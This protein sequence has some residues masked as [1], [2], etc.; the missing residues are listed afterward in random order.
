MSDHFQKKLACLGI[1]RSP[2]CVRPPEGNGGAE[3]FIRTPKENLLWVPTVDTVEQL[4]HAL[5]KC[6]QGYN[7][8]WLIARYGLA[9]CGPPNRAASTRG[10][11]RLGS[12]QVSHQPRAVQLKATPDAYAQGRARYVAKII[13]TGIGDQK[14]EKTEPRR[15]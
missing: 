7:A 13:C 15:C 4:R 3:R 11:G 8:T 2:A 1:A 9:T 10:Q 12:N 6:R 5:N 14:F